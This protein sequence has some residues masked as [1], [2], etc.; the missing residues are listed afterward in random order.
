MN[1]TGSFKIV[2]N[3]VYRGLD[4]LLR[5]FPVSFSFSGQAEVRVA[6]SS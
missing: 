4:F 5:G 1:L 2:M 6:G 3:V